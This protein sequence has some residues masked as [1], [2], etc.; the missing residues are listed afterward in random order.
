[1]CL[2]LKLISVIALLPY[3]MQQSDDLSLKLQLLIALPK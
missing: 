2:K 3:V 1:M